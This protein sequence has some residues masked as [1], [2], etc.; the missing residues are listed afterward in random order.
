MNKKNKYLLNMLILIPV[1]AYFIVKLI[2][3][4]PPRWLAV[5]SLV[6]L[7]TYGYINILPLFKRSKR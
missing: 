5:V 6:A 4:N 2:T 1:L 7:I 3:D